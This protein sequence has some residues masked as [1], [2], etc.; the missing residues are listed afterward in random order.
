MVEF[1]FDELGLDSIVSAP[2]P[3][4]TASIRILENLGFAFL[5][6][7]EQSFPAHGEKKEVMRFALNRAAY[8]ARD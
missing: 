5:G 8:A 4:N 1:A 3:T 7:E 2:L 6:R